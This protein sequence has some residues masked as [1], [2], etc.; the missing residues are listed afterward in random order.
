MHKHA[1]TDHR[2]HELIRTRWSPYGFDARAVG[3][4]DLQALF[5]AARWAPSS[6]N[7][8]PWSFIVG[9]A[10]T[11][12]FARVLGCLIEFNQ[13]WARHAPVLV[14]GLTQTLFPNKDER[15]HWAEHDLG[16]AAGNICVEA[17]ARGLCVHQMAGIVP[18]RVRS[19]F[20]VP[21]TVRPLTAMAI[22]YPGKSAVPEALATRDAATRE[23]MPQT[24]F[25]FGGNWGEQAAQ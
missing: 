18:E 8:Q 14:L 2:I 3:D 12:Q 19:E 11:A 21:G 13:S 6:Y 1:L 10:G 24:A 16:L 9:M 5:E 15:N 4:A 20:A 7:A 17:T 25:V 22:G 23:R